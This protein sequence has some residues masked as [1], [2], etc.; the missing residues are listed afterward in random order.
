MDKAR[1][2]KGLEEALNT[3]ADETNLLFS[4]SDQT[5]AT[6]S[7]M[8]EL[9]KQTYYALNKFKQSILDAMKD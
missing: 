4:G 8:Q 6:K 1:L 9:S 7:D 3:F 2:G 5:P